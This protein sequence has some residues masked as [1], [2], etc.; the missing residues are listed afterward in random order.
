MRNAKTE[1]F[2]H[3]IKTTF[4]CCF[5]LPHPDLSPPLRLLG[6]KYGHP[7]SHCVKYIFNVKQVS[8]LLFFLFC[9]SARHFSGIV[10]MHRATW[11]LASQELKMP[12][13]F[14]GRAHISEREMLKDEL[15]ACQ[16][17]LTWSVGGY[18]HFLECSVC[19]WAWKVN[20]PQCLHFKPSRNYL[21]K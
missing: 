1:F 4:S 19:S 9:R 11:W 3:L 13:A 16:L 6:Q 21:R 2:S 10:I 17:P 20:N 7:N 12:Q 18:L 8:P 15:L 5:F 14:L